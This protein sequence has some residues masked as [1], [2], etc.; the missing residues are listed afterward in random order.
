MKYALLMLGCLVSFSAAAQTACEVT[1]PPTAVSQGGMTY[2]NAPKGSVVKLN[3]RV[4]TQSSDGAFVFGVARDATGPLQLTVAPP[5]GPA[6]SQS[7]TVTPRAF[8]VERVNGVP[9]RTANPT[10]EIAK[11]IE[12]EQALVTAVRTRNDDRTDYRQKFIWPVQGRISGR[13]GSSRSYNGSPGATHSGMDIAAGTGTP[14]KAPAAGVVTFADPSLYLTGGTVV[15]DHGQGI[16]SNFLHMSRIDVNVGDIIGQGQ[17]VG[18]VGAT[19]RAT[20]PHLHWGMNWF[21]TRIDPLL[22]LER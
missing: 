17:V 20:G 2:G 13:F 9:P 16:S 6:K 7:I 22:L 18:A 3:D 10:G 8:P 5:C 12:R 21:D 11:R 1:L 19:G 15:L 4:L 14:I